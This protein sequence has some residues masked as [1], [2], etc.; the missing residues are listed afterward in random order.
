[1]DD[2]KETP[3][4]VRD[5]ISATSLQGEPLYCAIALLE[6][7]EENQVAPVE[8]DFEDTDMKIED[9]VEA[10]QALYEL[11]VTWSCLEKF[12]CGVGKVITGFV[13]GD[14]YL[15]YWI[16]ETL[17]TMFEPP[18]GFQYVVGGGKNRENVQ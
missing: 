15:R 14:K 3:K 1:M 5:I 11:N 17:A 9:G 12:S 18:A 8:M 13:V 2:K 16:G 10:L 7:A 6:L 4:V